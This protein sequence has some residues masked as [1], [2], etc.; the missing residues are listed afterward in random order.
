MFHHPCFIW[1]LILLSQAVGSMPLPGNGIIVFEMTWDGGVA[2]DLSDWSGPSIQVSR[3]AE[4]NITLLA[5]YNDFALIH[6]ND[7][8]QASVILNQAQKKYICNT[9]P[10]IEAYMSASTVSGTFYV[11]DCTHCREV[12]ITPLDYQLLQCVLNVLQQ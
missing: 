9:T 1:L 8:D 4:E 10:G 3:I 5:T 2:L 7:V 6:Q 11:L 12:F